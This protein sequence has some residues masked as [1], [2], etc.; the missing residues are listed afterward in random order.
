MF[1]KNQIEHSEALANS[2]LNYFIRILTEV[3]ENIRSR[4]ENIDVP[5]VL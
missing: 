2:H 4:R 1:S 3:L 5:Q